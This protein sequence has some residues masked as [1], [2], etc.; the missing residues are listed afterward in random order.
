MGKCIYHLFGQIYQVDT[1]F[2]L[3]RLHI[4]VIRQVGI[5]GDRAEHSDGKHDQKGKD[6]FI[7]Q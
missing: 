5:V 3:F 1:L 7:V 4:T 2:A 6:I